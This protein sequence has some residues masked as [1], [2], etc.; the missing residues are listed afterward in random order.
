MLKFLLEAMPLRFNSYIEPFIG[1]GALYFHLA[2]KPSIISD[3]N[4]ELISF[5][6]TVS[7]NPI[8][9]HSA[10]ESM[11]NTEEFFY[12][13]RSKNWEELEPV[14]AAA[15]TLFLNKT[16]F[17]GLYRVNKKG[18]FNVPYGR[19]KRVALPNLETL[20]Q[21]SQTLPILKFFKGIILKYSNRMLLQ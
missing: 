17:N 6:R 2:Y 12:K 10:L 9:V 14:H 18:Q 16:C 21:I 13:L 8:A 11:E 4:T 3:S 5:Y 19:Y 15:R 1:G 7:T 20:L